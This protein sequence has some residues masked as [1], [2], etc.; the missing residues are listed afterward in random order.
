MKIYLASPF[1]NDVER[2]VMVAVLNK[3]RSD[4]Y[5][6]YAP[7]E[8]DQ[9]NVW[10]IDNKTWGFNVFQENVNAIKECDEVWAINHGMYSDS[11]TAWECGFAYGIGKTVRQLLCTDI[12]D[13]NTFSLMMLNGCNE[14][15]ALGLYLANEVVDFD[16]NDFI[17][18]K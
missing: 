11:G 3:M 5:D 8:H 14:Y 13:D 1:F 9:E 10:E 7:Y 4:G 17:E 18:Q 12:S 15:G 2:K 16:I 6:V